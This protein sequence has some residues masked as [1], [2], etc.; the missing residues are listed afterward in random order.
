[1]KDEQRQEPPLTS[2]LRDAWTIDDVAE[3]LEGKKDWSFIGGLVG[4][5]PEAG[6]QDRGAL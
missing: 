4:D 1:M 5:K 3:F 2:E 6:G